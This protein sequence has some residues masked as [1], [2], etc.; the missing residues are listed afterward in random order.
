MKKNAEL[1]NLA[2]TVAQNHTKD[3]VHFSFAVSIVMQ[4]SLSFLG[5][6]QFIWKM[7]TVCVNY[8]KMLN[9]TCSKLN[10]SLSFDIS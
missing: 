6:L 9:L 10:F 3:A 2:E 4:I 5:K 7:L 8:T 1:P